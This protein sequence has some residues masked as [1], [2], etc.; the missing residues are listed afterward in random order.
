MR[1][2]L[3]SNGLGCGGQLLQDIVYLIGRANEQDVIYIGCSD[4]IERMGVIR[5]GNSGALRGFSLGEAIPSGA[6]FVG[7]GVADNCWPGQE[8]G[9]HIQPGRVAGISA[10]QPGNV[11]F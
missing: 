7:C 2:V 6:G 11:L 8:S 3:K 9:H 5:V 4:V 1:D 10:K